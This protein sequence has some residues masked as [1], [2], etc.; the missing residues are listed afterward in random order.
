MADDKSGQDLLATVLQDAGV[1]L[2][3]GEKT[4]ITEVFHKIGVADRSLKV[5]NKV[6]EQIFLTVD[7]VLENNPKLQ[8]FASEIV[9]VFVGTSKN[10]EAKASLAEELGKVKAKYPQPQKRVPQPQKQA[11]AKDQKEFDALVQEITDL[12]KNKDLAKEIGPK[13]TQEFADQVKRLSDAYAKAPANKKGDSLLK[14]L[15][16]L[17]QWTEIKQKESMAPTFSKLG[18]IISSY[19]KAV[20]A[21]I[22]GNS[23]AAAEHRLN[24]SQAIKEL[25]QGKKVSQGL[26]SIKGKA[27]SWT[28]KVTQEKAKGQSKQR[29]R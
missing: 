15:D 28:E 9:D 7:R 23:K 22:S 2:V 19:S 21:L 3:D 13:N 11:P 24:A 14:N 26:G 6:R 25:T 18:T 27:Q 10:L 1:E 4:L 8:P 16:S 20:G 17:K 5:M 12:S 29:S